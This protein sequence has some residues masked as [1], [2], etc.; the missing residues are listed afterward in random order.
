LIFAFAAGHRR[1]AISFVA[2]TLNPVAAFSIA[3]A[4]SGASISPSH[5]AYLAIM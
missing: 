1:I 2:F 4:W 5:T 3:V